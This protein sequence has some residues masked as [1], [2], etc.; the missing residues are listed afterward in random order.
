VI[1]SFRI[2]DSPKRKQLYRLDDGEWK[3]IKFLVP[4][5]QCSHCVRRGTHFIVTRAYAPLSVKQPQYPVHKR[6]ELG[7]IEDKI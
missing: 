2:E 6:S 4:N 1:K 3:Q 5:K 7:R